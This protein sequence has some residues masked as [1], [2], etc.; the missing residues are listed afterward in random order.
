VILYP[1]GNVL[2]G[3]MPPS[4]IAEIL[5]VKIH[6]SSRRDDTSWAPGKTMH[7]V[8]PYIVK[9]GYEN[10]TKNMNQGEK[11]VS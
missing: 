3:L 7:R 8:K 4:L 2:H 9:A 5:A 11:S 1:E 6:W 10:L